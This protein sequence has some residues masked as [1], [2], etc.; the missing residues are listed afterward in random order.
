MKEQ[1]TII[2]IG[3]SGCGKGTQAKLVQQYLKDNHDNKNIF[4]LETGAHFR[5][6]FKGKSYSHTLARELYEQGERQPGFLAIKIWGSVL[7]ENMKEGEHLITDGTPR[8]LNEAKILDTALVFY[9]REKPTVLFI[10]V[11]REWAKTR[12]L[13]RGREDDKEVEDVEHRLDWFE[14]DVVPAIEFFRSNPDYNFITINGEQ[15][16]EDVHKEIVSKVFTQM[17]TGK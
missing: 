16:I 2:F 1:E 11:P 15:S 12:L 9:K 5:K 4:Y 8:S 6:F 13:E 3:N 14:E 7:L 10:D 17:G